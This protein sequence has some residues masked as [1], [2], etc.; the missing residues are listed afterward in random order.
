MG[1]SPRG[2]KELDVTEVTEHERRVLSFI[3]LI[4][5]AFGPTLCPS[6][7]CR[8]QEERVG[9]KNKSLDIFLEVKNVK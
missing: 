2:H 8:G 7:L 3:S 6:P 5:Y 9:G 1:Y 4:P